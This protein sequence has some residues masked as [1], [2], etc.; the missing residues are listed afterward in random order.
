MLI[1][2]YHI[3][4]LIWRKSLTDNDIFYLALIEIVGILDLAKWRNFLDHEGTLDDF[5][6]ESI[7]IHIN[8]NIFELRMDDGRT[9]LPNG[10][11]KCLYPQC[12]KAF[13]SLDELM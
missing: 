5:L 3:S 9:E 1:S 13:R 10:M 11:H 7:G 2:C 6:K 12:V 4:K 8:Q